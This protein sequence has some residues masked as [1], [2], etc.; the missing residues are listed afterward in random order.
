[1]FFFRLDELTRNEIFS[2]PAIS[3]PRPRLPRGGA[4]L[5]RRRF[6]GSHRR[7]L[8]LFR[9]F[10][11]RS[12]EK[13]SSTEDCRALP[14]VAPDTSSEDTRINCSELDMV[15]PELAESTAISYVTAQAGTQ[16]L[17]ASGLRDFRVP[18]VP[19]TLSVLTLYLS[20]G[21]Q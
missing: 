13:T 17:A 21:N 11:P 5:L 18:F 14:P 16:P 3:A 10:R 9:A 15:S 1:M 8:G 12:A 7:P 6:A 2:S 4:P 20:D 19:D